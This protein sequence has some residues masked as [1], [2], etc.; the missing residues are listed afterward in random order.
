MYY[1]NVSIL[2][3]NIQA[4]FLY[5]T[6]QFVGEN[7]KPL[8]CRLED[9]VMFPFSR[10]MLLFHGDPLMKRVNEIIDRVVEAVL[11]NHWISLMWNKYTVS[12]RMITIVQ[13][14]DGYYSFN[15]YHLQ[16]VIYLLL[17]GCCLSPL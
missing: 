9:G 5:A 2:L 14:L 10:T 11:H 7:S 13:Q 15:V 17:M 6:G 8:I 3:A 1:K 16:F 12:S 4:E